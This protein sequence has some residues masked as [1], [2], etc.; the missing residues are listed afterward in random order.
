MPKQAISTVFLKG[1]F[2]A[3]MVIILALFIC[4]AFALAAFGVACITLILLYGANHALCRCSDKTATRLSVLF[5]LVYLGL[6][7][8]A[9]VLLAVEPA[10]DFGRV[11]SGALD[12]AEN[13]KLTTTLQYF[14]ESNNNFF[15]AYILSFWFKIAS[16]AH[17][18]PL[19]AG[20]LLNCLAIWLS[21]LAL[22][23][24]VKTEWNIQRGC[25]FLLLV[26]CFI[27]LYTYAPIFYT[28]TLSLPFISFALLLWQTIK[29]GTP[30]VRLVCLILLGA[31]GIIGYYVKASVGIVY[32]AMLLLAL[33]DWKKGTLKR[34]AVVA[35]AAVC[36]S[37]GYSTLLNVTQAIDLTELD[38]YKLPYEHYVMMGLAGNG[39]YNPEDYELSISIDNLETRKETNVAQIKERLAAYGVAGYFSFLQIKIE[40]TWLDGTYYAPQKL[41]ID[42]LQH[43]ILS[44]FFCTDGQYYSFYKTVALGA[45]LALLV[46]MLLSIRAREPLVGLLAL[47]VFGLFLFLLIWETR[48]RY[49]LNF[50]PVFLLLA[51]SGLAGGFG[52]LV[53][54]TWRKS[55]AEPIS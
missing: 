20:I 6:L 25:L 54:P 44:A 36:V 11:Y 40:Y 27:P 8:L 55:V 52:H 23:W 5:L 29:R 41:S 46:L 24:V 48:S 28:D 38:R 21:A 49:L 51:Q 19:Y 45:Q 12:L 31:N 9:G 2:A 35:L 42:P 32:V 4:D 7:L 16:L 14:L 3:A 37:V 18:T 15:I 13:G 43:T 50:T 1:F 34:I 53:R 10:W 39:G 30:K 22:F 26:L 33:I 17:I 47:S